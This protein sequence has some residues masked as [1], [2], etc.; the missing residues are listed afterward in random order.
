LAFVRLAVR[1]PSFR[2]DVPARLL[3][4]GLLSVGVNYDVADVLD[5]Q[6]FGFRTGLW[7]GGSL[8]TEET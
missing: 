6:S 1:V 3:V 4:G 5:A 2:R 8:V 7:Q